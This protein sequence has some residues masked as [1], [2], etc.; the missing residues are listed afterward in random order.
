MKE[1]IGSVYCDDR[2]KRGRPPQG[3]LNRVETAPG[4]APHSD[5]ARA[6]RLAG[7]PGDDVLGVALLLL[8]VLA[9]GLLAA[10]AAGA[11]NI[12]PCTRV[13]AARHVVIEPVIPGEHPVVL[14][15]WQVLE[16]GWHLLGI[17]RRR[18]R[19]RR[20]VE[21][22]GELNAVPHRDL[23]VLHVHLSSGHA[24]G[25]HD[26]VLSALRS[27]STNC[28]SRRSRICVDCAAEPN[29]PGSSSSVT[30]AS[31]QRSISQSTSEMSILASMSVR[32]SPRSMPN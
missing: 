8:A 27:N 18:A 7:Q 28:S 20:K 9:V 5:C 4:Y 11:A 25:V 2:L 16:Q 29:R 32:I 13:A 19:M 23:H 15:V 31:W 21:R 14:A 22:R 24:C 12:H 10:T 6:P 1:I 30:I 3:N 26:R 17:R